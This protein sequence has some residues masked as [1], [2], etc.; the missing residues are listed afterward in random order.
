M[1]FLYCLLSGTLGPI[2]N[3]LLISLNNS[4]GQEAFGDHG[5]LSKEIISLNLNKILA[6]NNYDK[7]VI[8]F[9]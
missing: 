4:T 8:Y 7:L 1:S 2:I 9:L 3:A 5:Q 6:I